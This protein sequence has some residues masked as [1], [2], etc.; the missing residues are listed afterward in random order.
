MDLMYEI[1][2]CDD[3]D[4]E[5]CDGEVFGD[6]IIIEVGEIIEVSEVDE[7]IEVSEVDEIIEVLVIGE[8]IEVVEIGV[9]DVSEVVEDEDVDLVE[10]FKVGLCWVLGE[11]FV[12]YFY[13]GYENCV[14]VNFEICI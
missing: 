12:I 14:K 8:I 11:W 1:F 3:F 7:I 4:F 6:G 2:E 10:E 5:V 13:V 9:V